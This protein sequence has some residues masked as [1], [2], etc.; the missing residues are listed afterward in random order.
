[1]S[2]DGIIVVPQMPSGSGT[3]KAVFERVEALNNG[4]AGIVIDGAP[5]GPEVSIAA[6]I[7]D[8]VT[9]DN[10]NGIVAESIAGQAPVKTMVRNTVISNNSTGISV[11]SPQVAIFLG[12]STIS[13]NGTALSNP[14]GTLAS[15]GDNNIDGNTA[16]G[17]APSAVAFH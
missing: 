10:L 15:Y 13:G 17:T 2:S 1:M 3:I 9:A 11:S 7:A 8:S 16:F 6:T 5:S 14:S 12:H 4:A